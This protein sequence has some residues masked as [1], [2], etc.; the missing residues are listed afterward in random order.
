M[1]QELFVICNYG[2]IG[3]AMMSVAFL[4]RIRAAKPEA[5][6]ILAVTK[7]HALIADLVK[8]YGWLFVADARS[9]GALSRLTLQCLRARTT[10]IIRP[11]F[12]ATPFRVALF[13]KLLS[14]RNLR[15]SPLGFVEPYG[16][17]QRMYALRLVFDER[18]PM[19]Q[20]LCALLPAIGV[21][22]ADDSVPRFT[23]DLQASALEKYA[24]T[25]GA[26]L[27]LHF[28][29][30]NPARTLPK[31]RWAGLLRMAH[32]ALPETRIVLTGA[33]ADEAFVRAATEQSGVA[34]T[35]VFGESLHTVASLI[36]FSKGYIGPDTGITHIAGVLQARS[37]VI[38]NNSNPSWLP[39]YNQNAVILTN[40]AHCACDGRKGGSCFAEYQ[41]GKYYRCMLDIPD[42]QIL[43]EVVNLG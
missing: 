17:G 27:V 25:R 10:C 23:F 8:K 32:G 3:D 1:K 38:G 14:L 31:E 33:E 19:F 21:P 35:L 36:H 18:T 13:A 16:W 28:P 4:A 34:A 6:Y 12:G 22:G 5:A 30:A 29:A 7:R 39:R 43:A 24:L 20:N 40:N 41:G 15:N 9:I 42:E 26:Y 2:T 37:V 11:T